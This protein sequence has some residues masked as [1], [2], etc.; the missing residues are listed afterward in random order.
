MFR[1][2]KGIKRFK[3]LSHAKTPRGKVERVINLELRKAGKRE[4]VREGG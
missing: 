1:K 2:H 3:S 4:R